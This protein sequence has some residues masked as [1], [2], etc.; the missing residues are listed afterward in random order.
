M[1]TSNKVKKTNRP[2]KE[3]AKRSIKKRGKNDTMCGLGAAVS[4]VRT[5]A[6]AKKKCCG[7]GKVQGPS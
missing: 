3:A 2:S 1:V 6:G 4:I 5:V 7:K